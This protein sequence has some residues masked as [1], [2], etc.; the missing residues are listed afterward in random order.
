MHIGRRGCVLDQLD[1]V[2]AEHHLAW[3]D[4]HVL[5]DLEPF[6]P[7]RRIVKRETPCIVEKVHGAAPQVGAAAGS[8]GIQHLG[9]GPD[10]IRRRPHVQPL[11]PGE[12]DHVLVMARH[13]THAGGGVVPPLLLQQKALVN[14]VEGPLLPGRGGKAP[15]LLQRFDAGWAVVR[16]GNAQGIA[17]KALLLVQPF[18]IRLR[19]LPGERLRC[20]AQSYQASRPAAGDSPPVLR[21]RQAFASVSRVSGRQISDDAGSALPCVATCSSP[22]LHL[23]SDILLSYRLQEKLQA[24]LAMWDEFPLAPGES[25]SRT[26]NELAD[27]SVECLVNRLNGALAS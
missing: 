12:S 15:I 8:D 27:L 9:V 3:R 19:C 7:G 11:P 13:A 2:V 4:R 18:S 6:D 21:A 10:E 17:R 16:T 20:S 14:H 26:L 1:Q 24:L 22:T 5:A 23:A 25:T